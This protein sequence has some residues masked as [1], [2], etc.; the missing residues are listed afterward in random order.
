[1]QWYRSC[2]TPFKQL[3]SRNWAFASGGEFQYRMQRHTRICPIK[4][5]ALRKIIIALM[6]LKVRDKIIASRNYCL[7]ICKF[8]IKRFKFHYDFQVIWTE[9]LFL[10]VMIIITIQTFQFFTASFLCLAF[11]LFANFITISPL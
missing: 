8:T 9:I 7:Q 5:T 4:I 11:V 2:R 10:A 3:Y 6:I 1:M